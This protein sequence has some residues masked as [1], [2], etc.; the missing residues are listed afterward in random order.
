[1]KLG[2][3]AVGH[4]QPAWVSEG[5]AEYLKRMPRELPANVLERVRALLGAPGQAPAS[6]LRL[7]FAG[8][9]SDQPLLS[10]L[11]RRF[12]LDLTIVHGTGWGAIGY[13]GGAIYNAAVL[14]IGN[15]TLSG[16]TSGNGGAIYNTGALR[17]SHSTLYGNGSSYGGAIY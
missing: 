7:V 15:S 16:N 2:V 8:V 13:N 10:D 3:F 14:T 9:D 17:V 5:C 4:R 6:L 1:M 11:V 12:G